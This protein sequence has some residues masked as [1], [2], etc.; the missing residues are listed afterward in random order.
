[1]T[2]LIWKFVFGALRSNGRNPTGLLQLQCQHQCMR[3]LSALAACT[4]T[5]ERFSRS[6][7]ATQRH[8]VGCHRQC[9]A[10][11]GEA[12]TQL[13]FYRRVGQWHHD[14]PYV[15]LMDVLF[16]ASL[17]PCRTMGQQVE[18]MDHLRHSWIKKPPEPLPLMGQG[19]GSPNNRGRSLW[20]FRPGTWIN[21]S[22]IQGFTVSPSP[23][24]LPKNFHCPSSKMM[25]FR[26]SFLIPSYWP[27]T[28]YHSMSC[29]LYYLT[30]L[31]ITQPAASQ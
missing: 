4:S 7:D 15:F 24:H 13:C 14:V 29:A 26:V 1:M 10:I 9:D 20:P 27:C 21:Q 2:N 18:M 3:L 23:G 25:N 11:E 5:C 12:N 17:K 19:L 16:V 28:A 30:R 6:P 31:E 22:N 8:H